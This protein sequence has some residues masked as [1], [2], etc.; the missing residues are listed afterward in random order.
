MEVK[1]ILVLK[2]KTQYGVLRD[3]A[4]E[5][6]KGF[7]AKGIDTDVYDDNIGIDGPENVVFR[8]REYDLILAFNGI[9]LGVQEKLT[10]NPNTLFWSFLVDHPYYHHSRLLAKCNNHIVSCIDNNHVEYI[11]KYYPNIEH[12]CFVPHGG[13]RIDMQESIPLENRKYD[14]CFF[15]TYRDLKAYETQLELL[16][17]PDKDIMNGIAEQLKAGS[18][19]TLEELL[20]GSLKKSNYS[21][22]RKEFADLLNAVK[23]VDMYVRLYHRTVLIDKLT[24]EGITV[25]L[26]GNGWEHYEC[27]NKEYVRIHG[28]IPY[29]AVLETMYDS[30]IVLNTLP[31]FRDG[32][33][34]RVFTAMNCGAVCVTESNKYLEQLFEH[35][36]DVVFFNISNLDALIK[37]I[38]ELLSNNKKAAEIAKNGNA[39]SV[40][41]HLWAYRSD[42]IVEYA[43]EVLSQYKDDNCIQIND[44]CDYEFDKVIQYLKNHSE[45]MLVNKLRA[46]YN[47][48]E[49]EESE[50][51]R[52][53]QRLVVKK[54]L[55]LDS[56]ISGNI[57]FR[58]QIKDLKNNIEQYIWLYNSLE[59]DKSKRTLVGLLKNKISFVPKYLFENLATDIMF[60]NDNNVL[61]FDVNL[62]NETNILSMK[63]SIVKQQSKL[64]VALDGKNEYLWKLPKFIY[65]NFNVNKYYLRY[66]GKNIFPEQI[67][68]YV[69]LNG[70]KQEQSIKRKYAEI[71]GILNTIKEAIE[72]IESQADETIFGEMSFLFSDIDAAVSAVNMQLFDSK[73][74]NMYGVKSYLKDACSHK[75]KTLIVVKCKEW[76]KFIETTINKRSNIKNVVD[77]RFDWLMD[78]A[79]YVEP[80]KILENTLVSLHNMPEEHIAHYNMYYKKYHYMWGMLDT[81][82]KIYDVASNRVNALV[83]HREDFLWLYNLLG[84]YRSRL[85]LCNTLYNWITFDINQIVAM[86]ENNFLDYFDLDLLQCDENEVIVDLGAYTG[87]SMLDYINTYGVYKKIYCYEI[88]KANVEKT[89]RN[90]SI[91]DN[92]E[93]INKGVGDK[94]GIMYVDEK[95]TSSSNS[96]NSIS[97]TEIQV[98]T[99]DDDIKEKITM[100][101]MDIEGAEQSALKGCRRHIEEE[102]PKLLICVYHNNEDIWKIPR[103]IKEIRDDY[104][105]YLRSNGA[106]WGPSEIVLFAL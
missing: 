36:K 7:R 65:D 96:V 51:T 10:K 8:D 106:Q 85:V 32:S 91:Y 72:Y 4:D 84:D 28:S 33:H 67:I 47:Y 40:N 26:F 14:V 70:N 46:L 83:Q 77:E 20:E 1:K 25:N 30:K 18:H 93:V 12:V 2:G 78:Y 101:K 41:N 80:S 27:K 63:E 35:D 95:A 44:S 94:N 104:K 64:M 88:T 24:S 29:S 87:D 23:F 55:W 76:I 98:V 62:A 100:I 19:S 69:E 3:F 16:P 90:L 58:D 21:V 82:A 89:K 79:E 59:D 102:K 97:G 39:I 50:F 54:G 86:K 75:N 13:D 45:R 60:E 9:M 37:D 74:I 92:I 81:D 73:S 49:M 22:T 99:I 57:F 15:G 48:Y 66:Y 53:W 5:I 38:K 56:D 71:C 34:E 42:N 68:L 6:I 52:D 11:K 31:L 17:Q 105:L 43:N 61:G 103:M